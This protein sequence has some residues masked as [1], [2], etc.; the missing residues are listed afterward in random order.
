MKSHKLTLRQ[1][2]STLHADLIGKDSHRG[3]TL[4]YGWLANQTGHFALGFIPTTILYM[5]GVTPWLSFFYVAVFWLIF[6]IFNALSPLYKKEY[7]GNGTFKPAWGNLTFD[8][9]TD[10]CFFW[11]GSLSIY[12]FLSSNGDL[13]YWLIALLV[14]LVFS[15]R[16]WFFTKL[17]QQNAFFPYQFRLSQWSGKFED[18]VA[19]QQIKTLLDQPLQ[20]KHFIIYG[21]AKSGKTT[22]SVGIGNELAI[23]HHRSTFT[24]LNKWLAKLSVDRED[25]S[26]R[27]LGLWSWMESDF[28]IIDDINPVTPEGANKFYAAEINDFI[29]QSDF[30]ERNKKLIASKSMAWVVG[31]NAE[32]DSKEAWKSM[33]Q[34]CGVDPANIHVIRLHVPE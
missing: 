19:A 5:K 26:G 16:Y 21:P 33:L 8:T 3:I 27:S 6:E 15:S 32:T 31:A 23:R 14:F 4:T 22:I 28:V 30:A 11:L 17:Y 10:L 7:K 24:T 2:W 13:K 9:F 29:F 12:A 18:D 20:P 1:I 25:T 34:N